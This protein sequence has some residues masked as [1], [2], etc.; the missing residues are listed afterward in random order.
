MPNEMPKHTPT[1]TSQAQRPRESIDSVFTGG[2]TWFSLFDSAITPTQGLAVGIAE[3]PA[4]GS[5]TDHWHAQP[6]LYYILEGEGRLEVD[7]VAYQVRKGDAIYVP[8]DALHT[9]KNEAKD[10]L[11]ILYVFP[12]SSLSEV[13]YKFPDGKERRFVAGANAGGE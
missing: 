3:F 6:E 5:N 1:I 8:G 2:M 9:L 4:G 13:Q 10:L 12:A 11:K 7:G